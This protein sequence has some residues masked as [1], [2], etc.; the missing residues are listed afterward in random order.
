MY[1]YHEP[2]GWTFLHPCCE[3]KPC[4]KELPHDCPWTPHTGMGPCFQLIYKPGALSNPWVT[5]PHTISL[6]LFGPEIY[7][8]VIKKKITNETVLSCI[9]KV[10]P[11]VTINY[12]LHYIYIHL[13]IS[14]KYW[15]LSFDNIPLSTYYLSHNPI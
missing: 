9:F 11:K 13:T 5:R 2:N 8:S 12:D 7:S 1:Q 3:F 10:N 14:Y 6:G 15:V 4:W